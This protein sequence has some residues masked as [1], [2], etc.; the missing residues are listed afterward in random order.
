MPPVPDGVG[1]RPWG[2]AV[3]V[4]LHPWGC[5]GVM[6]VCAS[7]PI[8]VVGTVAPAASSIYV[9]GVAWVVLRVRLEHA[10]CKAACHGDGVPMEDPGSPEGEIV[11]QGPAVVK[12]PN[13]VFRDGSRLV[14]GAAQVGLSGR[15]WEG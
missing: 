6:L 2:G 4:P 15:A 12:E 8:P 9:R 14:D 1:V 10:S 3:G 13:K 5:R 11:F 7:M